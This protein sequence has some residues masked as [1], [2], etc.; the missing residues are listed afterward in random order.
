MVNK[1]ELTITQESSQINIFSIFNDI[2]AAWNF[3]EN[4]NS[5]YN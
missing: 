3:Y 2:V 5:I 1:Y 4:M